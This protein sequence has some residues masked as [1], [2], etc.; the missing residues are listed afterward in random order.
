MQQIRR[1]RFVSMP[2]VYWRRVA[3]AARS[4]ALLTYITTK[5]GIHAKSDL[6][7]RVDHLKHEA[8]GFGRLCV[9]A[10]VL[11]LSPSA[12]AAENNGQRTLIPKIADIAGIKVGYSSMEELEGQL[13]KG[14][15]AIGG[16]PNG[17]RVWRVKGT[18]W[19]IY[20]DAFEYSQRGAVVDSFDIN[21]D[22][23]PGLDV[24]YARLNKNDFAWLGKISV[25]MDEGKL[26]DILKEK[27]CA[28]TKVAD[29]WQVK[30]KGS[31]PL[32]SNPI[33]PF[34]EWTAKFIIKERSLIGM[35]LAARQGRQQK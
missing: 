24:P 30:A 9:A 5:P 21:V 20:A 13:G 8:V 7:R 28:T 35:Q 2:N 17:A 12:N 15:I 3:D 4:A 33:S 1:L 31:S 27:S 16:H 25:G 14:K 34:Q 26:L 23:K 32:T 19:V 6:S 18:P 22:P 10:L 29:G 11:L